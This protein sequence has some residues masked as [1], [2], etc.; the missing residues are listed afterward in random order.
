MHTYTIDHVTFSRQKT[1]A[2]NVDLCAAVKDF[3]INMISNIAV[4]RVSGKAFVTCLYRLL[5]ASLLFVPETIKT[6]FGLSN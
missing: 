6:T 3:A 1:F 5:T 4:P 2:V